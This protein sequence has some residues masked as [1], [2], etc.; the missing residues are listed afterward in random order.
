MQPPWGENTGMK[1]ESRDSQDDGML[2][3]ENDGNISIQIDNQT[4]S[5]SEIC[6]I[7]HLGL[8][9]VSQ[10]SELFSFILNSRKL[11]AS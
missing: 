10:L 8:V 7:P 4:S 3:Y 1:R 11:G 6:R 5:N 9:L 2:E